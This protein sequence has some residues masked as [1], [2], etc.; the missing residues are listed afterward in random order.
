MKKKNLLVILLVILITYDNYGQQST[1]ENRV[2]TPSLP[3]LLIAADSR[4]AGMADMGVATSVDAFSQQFN[5]A[6]YVFSETK[7]GIGLAYTPYLRELVNDIN[8][9]QLTYFNRINDRSAF[10]GSLRYFSFGDVELRDDAEQLPR[11]VG[12]NNLSFDVS[13]SLRLSEQFSMA[14]TGR[15]IRSDQ[16]IPGLDGDATAAN[17]FAADIS[18][19]YQSEEIFYR[20]FNGRWRAGA[21]ITNIGPKIR[22]D[23]AGQE[24]YIPTNLRLGGGFDFILDMSNRIG[25]YA[26]F[27]KLLVPTPPE[28]LRDE[29]GN[30]TEEY[31]QDLEDYR[32]GDPFSGMINS[33]SDAPDG[34]SEELKEITW[35]LGAEYW[36]EDAFAFRVGYFH[37][38]EEKGFR[39]YLTLGAGF[40]F[41]AI[42]IDASYLFSTAPAVVSPLEGTLRFG[43]TFNFGEDTYIEY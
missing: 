16:R 38:S 30:L 33:F 36:F 20:D 9:G 24:N 37:E 43:L 40:N 22:F 3:F 17:S 10:A 11:T 41:N 28:V 5:A 6:K 14:V 42:T 26:E 39:Q 21:A 29:Q 34:F 32:T 8:I 7:S 4:S 1:N 13:Y 2:I 35:A 27:N 31:L 12:P 23:D 18:A 19:F 15:Y 25:I